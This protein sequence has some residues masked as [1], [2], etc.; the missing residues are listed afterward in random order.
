M[1]LNRCESVV[2]LTLTDASAAKCSAASAAYC[3]GETTAACERCA[4]NHQAA[5]RRAGCASADVQRWCD[6]HREL[7]TGGGR[8]I[9]MS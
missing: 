8:E 6:T 1:L 9:L 2:T 4:G 7:V 3:A 5:L